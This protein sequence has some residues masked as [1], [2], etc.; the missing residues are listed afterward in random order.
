MP[1]QDR[2]NELQ[3]P[4]SEGRNAQFLS[5]LCYLGWLGL[6]VLNT[7]FINMSAIS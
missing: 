2:Q 5:L 4:M 3:L 1:K 6:M 7:T